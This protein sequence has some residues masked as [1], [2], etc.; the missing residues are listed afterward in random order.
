MSKLE[1][2]FGVDLCFLTIYMRDIVLFVQCWK[3]ETFVL[4]II[5]QKKKFA[6]PFQ[7]FV[8]K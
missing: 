2:N 8:S 5:R 3:T 1:T 6:V 7:I 4:H